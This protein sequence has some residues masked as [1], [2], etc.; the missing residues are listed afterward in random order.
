MTHSTAHTMLSKFNDSVNVI[1]KFSH[2]LKHC[3]ELYLSTFYSRCTL[4][5][6]TIVNIT[7]LSGYWHWAGVNQFHLKIN[8]WI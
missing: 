7:L 1:S 2:H 8:K 4:E 6:K 3:R 5:I